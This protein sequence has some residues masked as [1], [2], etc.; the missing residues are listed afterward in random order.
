L[1]KPSALKERAAE[2]VWA[3]EEESVTVTLTLSGHAGL[4]TFMLRMPVE[5]SRVTPWGAD[6]AFH[7]S[8][9]FPFCAVSWKEEGVPT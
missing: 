6:V 2:A 9:A 4:V 1:Y 3:G 5:L 7:V 8:G